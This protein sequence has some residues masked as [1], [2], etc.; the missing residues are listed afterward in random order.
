[1]FYLVT[2][3]NN[4]TELAELWS[5]DLASGKSDPV[6]TGQR[7]TD[8][9]FSPDQSQV[10]FSVRKGA[11]SQIYLAALDR[12]SPPRLVAK[13]GDFVTFAGSGALMFLHLGEKEDYLARV[14]IDGSG[15]ERVLN[16]PIASKFGV[17]PD[18][19]WAAVAGLLDPKF[20]PGTYAVSLQDHSRRR[21][22]GG[23]CNVAWSLD[24]KLLY[25]SADPG[26]TSA[27]RTV[28]VPLPRGFRQSHFPETG[29]DRANEEE[30]AGIKVIRR[31]IMS[32]GPDPDTYAF[33]TAAF[34][35]NLFR[36]PLH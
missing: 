21:I 29:L 25:V 17:S 6:L 31:G 14:H 15:L 30:L 36:I 8:Y 27:G 20:P 34:Q 9:D 5:R 35:G 11:T 1:M 3:K 13:D 26:K 32:P 7:I 19:E 28:V 16:T 4:S 10:A 12:S 22:C 18:G 2:R 24:G 33:T 23:P